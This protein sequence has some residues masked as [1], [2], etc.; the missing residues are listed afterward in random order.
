VKPLPIDSK[1]RRLL[2]T[3]HLMAKQI[4]GGVKERAKILGPGGEFSELGAGALLATGGYAPVVA[5][6]H[7]AKKVRES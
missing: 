3:P 1:F 7:E 2:R 5:A 4:S 6:R